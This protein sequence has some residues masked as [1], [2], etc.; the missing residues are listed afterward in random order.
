M[1]EEYIAKDDEQH[2]NKIEK[3]VVK[4]ENKDKEYK[5]PGIKISRKFASLFNFS[6]LIHKDIESSSVFRNPG[7]TEMR[8]IPDISAF[9]NPGQ[10]KK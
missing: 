9:K 6:K 2:N 10:K 5:N 3:N 7:I 1:A 4:K 8:E